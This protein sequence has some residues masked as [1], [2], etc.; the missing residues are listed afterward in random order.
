MLRAALVTPLSGP[1]A[2]YGRAGTVALELWAAAGGARLTVHDAHPDPSAAVR[3]AERERPELLFG[4]YG[5][6]PARAVA[7]ATRRLVFNHGGARASAANLVDVLA[8]AH[9][10]FEGALAAVRAADAKIG[11]A[12]V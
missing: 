2:D 10:Y 6:G 1:L 4:P 12:H 7:A 8:P 5:S 3:A 9:T 11:R